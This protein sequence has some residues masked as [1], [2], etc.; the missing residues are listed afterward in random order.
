MA[1]APKTAASMDPVPF[2]EAAGCS[3]TSEFGVDRVG[4]RS[5][6]EKEIAVAA[7]MVGARSGVLALLSSHKLA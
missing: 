1:M 7:K 4:A 5:G 2:L 3:P 6:A